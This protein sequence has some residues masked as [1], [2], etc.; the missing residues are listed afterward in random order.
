MKMPSIKSLGSIKGMPKLGKG[1]WQRPPSV[2]DI[3][4]KPKV[5]G[6]REDPLEKMAMQGVSGSL[7]ERIIWKWLEDS[8][9]LYDVQRA[10]AGGR[11]V[12]GGMMLDFYVYSLGV[13][14]VVLRVQGEYWHRIRPGQRSKDDSQAFRLRAAGYIVVDLWEYDIYQAA[15]AD[16]V[17]RYVMGEIRG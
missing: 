1:G 6:E 2:R 3:V 13:A 12:A 17:G 4:V 9:H 15:L 11:R 10:F 8:G 5:P 16:R 7:P 14:R